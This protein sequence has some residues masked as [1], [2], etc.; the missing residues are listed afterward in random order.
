[1]DSAPDDEDNICLPSDILQRDGPSK[2]VDET[3]NVNGQA[4]ETHALG[5]HL[6]GEDLDRV[7]SLK[8]SETERV[9]EAKDVHHGEG[10]ST[11]W[12]GRFWN[13][14][15]WVRSST[16]LSIL[17]TGDGHSDPD[18]TTSNVGEEQEWA[19]AESVNTE[20]SDDSN[21][22]GTAGDSEVGVELS[23]LLSDTGGSK[24]GALVV[25][26][27]GVSSPLSKDGDSNIGHHSVARCS[28]LEKRTIIPPL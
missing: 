8:R 16:S 24:N 19:T 3:S 10:G 6:K 5:T 21:D 18:N 25:G 14:V 15:L 13:D 12:F 22:E 23:S 9:D 17:G 27:N 28:G 1:M 11:S 20:S 7:K 26:H 4:G 2:L